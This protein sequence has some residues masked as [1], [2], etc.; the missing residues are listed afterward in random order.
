MKQD[1]LVQ[2]YVEYFE[3]LKNIR[4][5]RLRHAVVHCVRPLSLP[6]YARRHASDTARKIMIIDPDFRAAMAVFHV[7]HLGYVPP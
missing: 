5:Q 2:E 1:G 6:L 3:E 4:Q 7:S